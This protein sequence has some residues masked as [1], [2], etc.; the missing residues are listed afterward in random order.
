M[1]KI[2]Y[3]E[4]VTY[5]DIAKK[6]AANHHIKRMSAQ[7]VGG[8]VG[9]NPICIIVPCHRVIGASNKLIGYGGGI[10]N[11]IVLLEI[12][13]HNLEEYKLSKEKKYE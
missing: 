11:K 8:S 2:P 1:D 9:A 4:V 5:G 13:G 10:K 7:A 12:E 6:I 3:G